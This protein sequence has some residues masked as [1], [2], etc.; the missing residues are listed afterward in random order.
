MVILYDKIMQNYH[1]IYPQKGVR[2]IYPKS[3]VTKK[4]WFPY[5]HETT[6]TIDLL[7]TLMKFLILFVQEVVENAIEDT[8][9]TNIFEFISKALYH[10]ITIRL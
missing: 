4:G 1:K 7:H 6:C 2:V 8:N 5:M 3:V 9:A 10:F